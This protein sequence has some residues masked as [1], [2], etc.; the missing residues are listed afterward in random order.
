M[1]LRTNSEWITTHPINPMTDPTPLSLTASPNHPPHIMLPWTPTPIT[2]HT[3]RTLASVC[4]GPSCPAATGKAICHFMLDP[5]LL[6]KTNS[7]LHLPKTS[8]PFKR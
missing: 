1:A 8:A 3:T 7:S 5:P 4:N 2:I 6:W